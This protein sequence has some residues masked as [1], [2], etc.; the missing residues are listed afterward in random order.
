[1]LQ[2]LQGSGF[3]LLFSFFPIIQC[4]L[5]KPFCAAEIRKQIN[6]WSAC[7]LFFFVC[8]FIF[9]RS[10]RWSEVAFNGSKTGNKM[11]HFNYGCRAS[12]CQY[13]HDLSY[14]K[15][16]VTSLVDAAVLIISSPNPSCWLSQQT[17]EN[18]NRKQDVSFELFLSRLSEYQLKMTQTL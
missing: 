6:Q 12:C 3:L 18:R 4:S 17:N 8:L 1:M 11:W 5:N 14:L 10:L 15:V 16:A 2:I 7:N 13:V 9:L